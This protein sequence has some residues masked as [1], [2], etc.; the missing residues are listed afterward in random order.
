MG[1]RIPKWNKPDLSQYP[2]A[3]TGVEIAITDPRRISKS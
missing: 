1:R 3:S 2:E